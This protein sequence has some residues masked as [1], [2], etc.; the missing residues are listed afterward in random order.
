MGTTR[1][2]PARKAAIGLSLALGI[3]GASTHAAQV[4]LADGTEVSGTVVGRDGESVMLRLPRSSVASIDGKPLPPPVIAGS[5]APAFSVVDLAG[6]TQTLGSAQ[7]DV[8]LLHFWA[9]WCPHCRHDVDLMKA[10]FVKYQGKGVR[11]VTVSVD[12][13]TNALITFVR[14]QHLPYPVVAA[15][16]TPNTSASQLPDLYETRGI[17]AYFLVDARGD[18]AKVMAGSVTEGKV[19]LDG[20]IKGLLPS[21]N[22]GPSTSPTRPPSETRKGPPARPGTHGA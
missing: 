22:A 18:V 8:T 13:D 20:L 6:A 21:S 1:R 2:N 12:Q 10:L 5:P 3:A 17:P 19:D 9:S 15:Y 7:G 11:V 4:K 16:S 14:D